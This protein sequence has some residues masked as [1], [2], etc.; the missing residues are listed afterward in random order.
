[1]Y[2]HG[3]EEMLL[4]GIQLVTGLQDE[5]DRWGFDE[6]VRNLFFSPFQEVSASPFEDE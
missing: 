2:S 5:G 4:R 3:V 6:C 1:M